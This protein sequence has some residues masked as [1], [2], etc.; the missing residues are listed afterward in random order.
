MDAE[1]E[2][3]LLKAMDRE[4]A[5]AS[6]ESKPRSGHGTTYKE[7]S[8]QAGRRMADDEQREHG[9]RWSSRDWF[10][11]TTPAKQ[12]AAGRLLKRVESA[13]LVVVRRLGGQARNVKLTEAGRGVV[14]D[15]FREQ[16][17]DEEWNSPPKSKP[18]KEDCR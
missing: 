1:T 14:L 10:G 6:G 15:I 5:F 13:G 2:G 7:R 11:A 3:L 17:T 9:P 18:R 16:Y 4:L 12:M 8:R